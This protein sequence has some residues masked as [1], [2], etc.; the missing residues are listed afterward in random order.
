MGTPDSL[1]VAQIWIK[2]FRRSGCRTARTAG[3]PDRSADDCG[4]GFHPLRATASCTLNRCQ[5][6]S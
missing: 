4:T 2:S 3:N 5:A 6:V 1:M